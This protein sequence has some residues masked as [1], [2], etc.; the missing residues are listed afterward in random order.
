MSSQ[1]DRSHQV[2]LV[3]VDF[4]IIPSQYGSVPSRCDLCQFLCPGSRNPVFCPVVRFFKKYIFGIYMLW[5]VS[6]CKNFPGLIFCEGFWAIFGGIIF[7]RDLQQFLEALFLW[8]I[9]SK[10]WMDNFF[11]KDL[12]Q[13][14]EGWFFS[15]WR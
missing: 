3:F 12:Q 9:F 11:L 4:I 8:E 6:W 14:L 7:V 10:F 13:F 5:G 2:C 15:K 1:N